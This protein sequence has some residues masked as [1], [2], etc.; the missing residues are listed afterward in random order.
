VEP[1]IAVTPADF[2]FSV[3]AATADSAFVLVSANLDTAIVWQIN[4]WPSWLYV[5]SNSGVTASVLTLRAARDY[6]PLGVYHDTLEIWSPDASNSPLKLPVTM[7]VD[8]SSAIA[9]EPVGVAASKP[10]AYP[11]P[12]NSSVLI[13][14]GDV[15]SGPQDYLVLD[16]LGRTVDRI[17][18]ARTGTG[19]GVVR[20]SPNPGRPSGVYFIRR[21]DDSKA[22]PV[23]V[24]YL[25]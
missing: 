16:L 9:E 13:E 11:N 20:W 18:L 8:I 21:A 14:F 25:K 10:V 23:R 17:R 5:E 7:T 19:E 24:L 6:Q 1:T 22:L 15:S 3:G 12:F 2:A 4:T